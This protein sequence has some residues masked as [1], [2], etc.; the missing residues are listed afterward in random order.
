M[1]TGTTGQVLRSYYAAN[2]AAVSGNAS[3]TSDGASGLNVAGNVAPASIGKASTTAAT[4][5]TPSNIYGSIQSANSPFLRTAHNQQALAALQQQG[6]VNGIQYAEGAS[7]SIT[8]WSCSA[9]TQLCAFT[10]STATNAAGPGVP[11]L[12]SGLTTGVL[13]DNQIGTVV[14]NPSPTTTSFSVQF[15][16]TVTTS[17][18]TETGTGVTQAVQLVADV[19]LDSTGGFHSAEQVCGIALDFPGVAVTQNFAGGGLQASQWDKLK[20]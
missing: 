18:A 13:L 20:L 14:Q 4:V 3:I 6:I 12:V 9:S 7:Y 15:P 10:T 1:N 16:F 19:L 5:T 2:G 17:S 11:I 8:A